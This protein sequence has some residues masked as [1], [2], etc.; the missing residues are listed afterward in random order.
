MNPANVVGGTG[1]R[2]KAGERERESEE[3]EKSKRQE[4]CFPVIVPSL[5]LPLLSSEGHA[6]AVLQTFF[7]YSYPH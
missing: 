2:E 3:M 4:C 6:F 5:F 7:F 1:A